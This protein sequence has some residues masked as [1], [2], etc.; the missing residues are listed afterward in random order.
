ML[1]SGRRVTDDSGSQR[2][3]SMESSYHV[4]LMPMDRREATLRLADTQEPA[5]TISAA[6]VR[7]AIRR[8]R[9][10]LLGQQHADGHWCAEL[11]G[12]TILESEIILLLAY[13]G[14][15]ESRLAR[16]AA[17]YLV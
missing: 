14:E 13:L 6:P 11:E 12:D 17:R 3:T 5:G 8:T 4:R 15:E 1:V 2:D 10:W 9:Q 7:K 16:H